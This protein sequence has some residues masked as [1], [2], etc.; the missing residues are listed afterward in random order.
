MPKVKPYSLLAEMVGNA[1]CSVIENKVFAVNLR[2]ELSRY[3][4]QQLEE[5][6]DES[7]VVKTIYEAY[8]ILHWTF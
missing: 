8:P 6:I 5:E 4:Y 7:S 2:N 3:S 1:V